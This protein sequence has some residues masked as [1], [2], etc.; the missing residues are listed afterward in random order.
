MAT[1]EEGSDQP[2]VEIRPRY[3][4]ACGEVFTDGAG[5]CPACGAPWSPRS[6]T[7]IRSLA[8][9][10]TE[11]R[12]LH[13][14][15]LIDNASYDAARTLYERR[16]DSLRTRI[17]PAQA[18]GRQSR[19]PAGLLRRVL[20]PN[21]AD[22]PTPPSV[23]A[24]VTPSPP[25]PTLGEW[26][27]ARQADI[28]LY[29]GAF[30][31][32]IAALI[33]VSYQGESLP[34]GIRLAVLLVYM[35]AFLTLGLLLPRWDRV[36]EAGPVFLALG[37]IMVPVSFIALRVQVLDGDALP[38]DVLWL[39]GAA[40]T[41]S[42]YLLLAVRGYGRW[43]AVPG[44]LALVVAWGAL[45]SVLSLPDEWFGTWYVA[46]AAVVMLVVE[47]VNV[48]HRVWIQRGALAVAALGLLLAHAF[49]LDGRGAALPLAYLLATAA[50]A[51]TTV[52]RPRISGYAMLPPLV[53]MT[54]L[55]GWWAAF[56][57]DPRWWC[58][59]IAG[60]AVGY[61]AVAERDPEHAKRWR[62][63]AAGVALV[64]LFAVYVSGAGGWERPLALTLLLAGAAWSAHRGRAVETFALP[65]LGAATVAGLLE[66]AGLEPVWYSYPA[67]AAAVAMLLSK[68]WWS[69]REPFSRF[70]WPYLL[71]V[72]ALVPVVC[73]P[74]YAEEPAHGV[75]GFLIAAL[76]F[77]AAAA[78]ADGALTRLML[79][80]PSRRSVTTE[81]QIL[82]RASSLLLYIAA[83]YLNARLGLEG[84]ARAWVFVGI[85]AAMWLGLAVAGRTRPALFGVL[86]PAGGM[87]MTVAAMLAWT[88]PGH[89]TL[90]LAAG[91]AGPALAF[92][93]V[94]RPL[95]WVIAVAFAI[96]A[97]IAAWDWRG[98]EPSNLPLALAA[99][100]VTLAAALAPRRTYAGDERSWS[101][102]LLTWGPWLAAIA[103]SAAL[104]A[105]RGAGLSADGSLARAREWA[106]LAITV[107]GASGAVIFEGL[108]RRARPV[109]VLG[110]AGLLIAGLLAIA[111]AQPEN[112]QAY[113]LPVG[114]YLIALGFTWRRSPALIDPHLY[115]HEAVMVAG[116]LVLLLPA[117][118]QSLAPG[119][120]RFGIELIAAGLIL[121]AAGLGFSTRWLVVGGVVTLTTVAIRWLFA[122]SAVPYWLT[123]GLAGMALLGFGVLLLV[124]RE[125][126]DRI[127][128]RVRRWWT[129]DR[130]PMFAP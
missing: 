14:D 17:D 36:R 42:L 118:E 20:D 67:L 46:V 3:C 58:V 78:E 92:A 80:A 72:A 47:F 96:A 61:V 45:G 23:A 99:I 21:A 37:A 128:S 82:A 1:D 48:R 76:L 16:M 56:G 103:A 13:E 86:A 9:L 53:A 75:V 40:A 73:I 121:L 83:G 109:V 110:S 41:A 98:F 122:E 113:T 68:S 6:F 5:E 32:S 116:M 39:L 106:V 8:T 25:R 19:S 112:V 91:T 15:G 44:T 62:I 63:V 22:V 124:E 108:R 126:W 35:T 84:G 28:L 29:L 120:G 52:R 51:V 54:A 95:L 93:A 60:A 90:I 65:A 33:F 89:A 38:D 74:L 79:R 57:L 117:A 127:R 31:L 27:A 43:Y 85:G 71:A 102:T 111:I 49:A 2:V 50:I 24:P 66:A 34:G 125:R 97:V 11:L 7:D 69:R 104:L 4:A 87:A 88:A 10:L 129:D 55:T 105:E 77:L 101:V 123:L 59:F 94:R 130:G 115:A 114:L 107:T 30:I 26:A 64:T 12:W 81:R 100:A 18:R 70:G 119:G